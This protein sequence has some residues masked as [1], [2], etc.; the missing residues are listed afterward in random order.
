MGK[1]TNNGLFYFQVRKPF[2]I[3]I[4]SIHFFDIHVIIIDSVK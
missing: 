2:F 1:V 3:V 4:K